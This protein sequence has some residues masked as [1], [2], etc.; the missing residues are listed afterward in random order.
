MPGRLE[1]DTTELE[2]IELPGIGRMALWGYRQDSIPV[3]N[4]LK[5]LQYLKHEIMYCKNRYPGIRR[6]LKIIRHNLIKQFENNLD[7]IWNDK[8]TGTYFPKGEQF[9]PHQVEINHNLVM[10][11]GI[12]RFTEIISGES[13]EYFDYMGMG[14]GTTPATFDDIQLE[15][16]VARVWLRT[17]GDVNSDGI[18]LKAT[19]IFPP[20]TPSSNITEFAAFDLSASGVMEFRVVIDGA[21]LGHIQSET[22]VQNSHS[23][24]FQ[25]VFN[26]T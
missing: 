4:Y 3:Y 19:A 12:T 5:N 6:D 13:T 22:F 11:D 20:G 21:P 16:E 23:I 17:S 24:V 7:R 25:S 26:T 8:R 18:V 14:T 1:A 9:E 2:N 10:W 15:V